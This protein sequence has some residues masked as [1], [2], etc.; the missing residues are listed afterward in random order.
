MSHSAFQIGPGVSYRFQRCSSMHAVGCA[1][2]HTVHRRGPRADQMT[3]RPFEQSEGFGLRLSAEAR[4]RLPWG[5]CQRA[6]RE[7]ALSTLASPP[8]CTAGNWTVYL[9]VSASVHSGNL[10]CG[11]KSHSVHSKQGVWPGMMTR[12]WPL[13]PSV[14]PSISG[15]HVL[16]SGLP[17]S[18]NSAPTD[19]RHP[20]SDFVPSRR[21]EPCCR[22]LDVDR[23]TPS[24][25]CAVRHG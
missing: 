17:S 8:A 10:V 9:G 25:L 11:G 4:T 6:Q 14:P 19:N 1:W 7:L 16:R 18:S 5:L 23:K 12:A 20:P 15:T 24:V 21:D 22:R 2:T 13:K 3:W